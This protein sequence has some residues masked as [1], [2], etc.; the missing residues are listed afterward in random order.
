MLFLLLLLLLLIYV[1]MITFWYVLNNCFLIDVIFF[2]LLPLRFFIL[3][4]VFRHSYWNLHFR[5][6]VEFASKSLYT[7]ISIVVFLIPFKRR[8]NTE[9]YVVCFYF[10]N[11]NCISFFLMWSMTICCCYRCC[12]FPAS[13]SAYWVNLTWNLFMTCAEKNNAIK[14][15]AM[16][17]ALQH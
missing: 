15:V 17:V 10:W 1:K 7:H 3:F 2:V 8:L 16:K 11:W 13:A 14:S 6:E 12:C 5:I 4:F 9:A